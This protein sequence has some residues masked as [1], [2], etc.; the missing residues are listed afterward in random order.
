MAV[1]LSGKQGRFLTAYIAAINA[2]CND[3]DNLAA[4]YTQWQNDA[5]ATGANPGADN[6][7]DALVQVQAPYA[8]AL[9]LNQAVGAVVAIQ[10]T[11]AAN[12]GYL[13]AMR[14]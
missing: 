12:R 14:P 2:L 6:I 3:A 9:Q 13:E 8:T 7:T 11:I 10:A 4:L 5:Y 1:D